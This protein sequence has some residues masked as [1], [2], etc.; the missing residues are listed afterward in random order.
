[1]QRMQMKFGFKVHLLMDKLINSCPNVANNKIF[2]T[3]FDIFKCALWQW[4]LIMWKRRRRKK[5]GWRK[6]TYSTNVHMKSVLRHTLKLY[7]P[8]KNLQNDWIVECKII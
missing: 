5:I 3:N 6:I 1:M 2:K 4:L 8:L 7:H